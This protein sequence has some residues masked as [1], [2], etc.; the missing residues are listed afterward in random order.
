MSTR[1]EKIYFSFTLKRRGAK[2]SNFFQTKYNN[3]KYFKHKS[4]NEFWKLLKSLTCVP[5][6]RYPSCVKAKKMMKNMTANPARSL[7]HL[8][9]V[10]DSC[11]I[12]LLKLMY[13]KIC[14][15]KKINHKTSLNKQV[16]ISSKINNT[17]TY[18]I[19]Q[20]EYRQW[21][22]MKLYK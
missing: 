3:I 17:L 4:Y 21:M 1:C 20:Y 18:S 19:C 11:V 6:K 12:V 2:R 13:L 22:K 10:D 9:R 7:A 8:P 14:Q 15:W 16:Y 5:N